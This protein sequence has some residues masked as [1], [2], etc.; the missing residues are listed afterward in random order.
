MSTHQERDVLGELL[1]REFHAY[2]AALAEH[3]EHWP[4]RWLQEWPASTE[5][6]QLRGRFLLAREAASV[7][8]IRLADEQITRQH[9]ERLE[10][11]RAFP[12]GAPSLTDH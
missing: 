2:A 1:F 4:E 6:A 10:Y 8:G 3:G 7:V 12:N 9:Q 11:L 5:L